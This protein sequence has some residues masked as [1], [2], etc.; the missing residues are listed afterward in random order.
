MPWSLDQAMGK[1]KQVEAMSTEPSL[2]KAKRNDHM[3]GPLS[4][5]KKRA[6]LVSGVMFSNTRRR[7]LIPGCARHVHLTVASYVENLATSHETVSP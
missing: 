5:R 1:A 7:F 3:S 6:K 4:I 2:Q